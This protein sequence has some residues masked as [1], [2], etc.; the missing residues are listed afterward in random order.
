MCHAAGC[1]FS[2]ALVG[3]RLLDPWRLHRHF[4]LVLLQCG[5]FAAVMAGISFLAAVTRNGGKEDGPRG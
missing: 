2:L 5:L 1:G 4:L 3:F